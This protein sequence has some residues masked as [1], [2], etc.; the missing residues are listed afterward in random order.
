VAGG[1]V[2]V[3]VGMPVVAPAPG[4]GAVS[5]EQLVQAA[6]AAL[7]AAKRNGRNRVAVGEFRGGKVA[8]G[9]AVRARA[10][11]GWDPA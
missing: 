9:A 4:A 7:Y 10:S 11:A 2:T 3:G 1:I 5:A 8:A 6:D